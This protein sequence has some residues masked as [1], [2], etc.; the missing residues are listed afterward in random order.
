MSTARKTRTCTALV[1]SALVALTA[2]GND[3]GATAD[4]ASS[5]ATAPTSSA[6]GTTAS[7]AATTPATTAAPTTAPTSAVSA[8][9]IAD[10]AAATRDLAYERIVVSDQAILDAALALGLPVAG[11]PGFADRQ[12]IPDYLVALADGVEVLPDRTDLNFEQLAAFDPDLLLINPKTLDEV[13]GPELLQEIAEVAEVDVVTTRP[14]R[15][16]LRDVGAAVG[17]AESAEHRIADTDAKIEAARSALTSEQLATEVSVIRC[18]GDSCRYLPGGTSFSGQVLDEL[19]VTRPDLQASDA[20]GRAFVE[21]SPERVDLLD[22][23]LIL[24]FGTDAD[25]SLAALQSNPLWNQLEAVQNDRV[26]MVDPAPWFTGNVLA[27]EYIVDDIVSILGA[28]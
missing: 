19:G 11:I 28:G 8:S 4:T 7:T 10:D 15:D 20:E 25:D 2:C 24:L 13:G 3:D 9:T 1:A 5:T 12:T 6:L 14:W 22:G 17:R 16:S 26:V 18:F 27:V 23:D 21:V